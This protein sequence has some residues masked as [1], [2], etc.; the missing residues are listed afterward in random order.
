[1]HCTVEDLCKKEVINVDNAARVGY[2]GDVE[3]DVASGCLVCICVFTGGAFRPAPPVRIPWR[4][5]VKIGEE[6]VL[7]RNV[8]APA[9]KT[10]GGRRLAG[11][12][13][14]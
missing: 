12:L 8:P 5:I 3:V 10:G 7:V 14:K 13:G 9:P 4:D 1:M 2:I 11:L 6:T